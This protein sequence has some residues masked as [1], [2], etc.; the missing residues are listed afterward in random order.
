MSRQIDLARLERRLQYQFDD[1]GRLQLAIT[2]KS[3]GYENNERLEFLGDAVLGFLVGRMLFELNPD[4]REDALSLGRAQLVRGETLAEVA[5]EMNLGEFLRMGLGARR[6]GGQDKTSILADSLEAVIGAVHEDGGIDA[7]TRVVDLLFRKR[8][9]SVDPGGLKDAKTSLQELL[10][11]DHRPL[12]QY[13][14]IEVNGEAHARSYTVRCS[15]HDGNESGEAAAS[16]RREAEK[17][18]AHIVLE[19]LMALADE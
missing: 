3:H 1:L 6:G 17:R 15:L 5:R 9:E 10:Q 16:S 12:P 2:H 8:A 11:G 13:D 7:V 14:V 19:K 4:W 18:A